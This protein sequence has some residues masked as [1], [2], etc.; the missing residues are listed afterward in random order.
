MAEGTA[1]A[2]LKACPGTASCPGRVATGPS[3]P[4]TLQKSSRT[5]P[6][7]VHAEGQPSYRQRPLPLPAPAP[8]AGRRKGRHPLGPPCPPVTWRPHLRPPRPTAPHTRTGSAGACLQ[9]CGARPWPHW[10]RALDQGRPRGPWTGC[11]AGRSHGL[12][13]GPLPVAQPHP[14]PPAAR[15]ARADDQAGG[16]HSPM[17]FRRSSSSGCGL[18]P[19]AVPSAGAAFPRESVPT[20]VGGA[21][22]ECVSP[23]ARGGEAGAG[24]GGV[25]V[26]ATVV[27]GARVGGGRSASPRGAGGTVAGRGVGTGSAEAAGTWGAEGEA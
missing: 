19:A 17:T 16:A 4:G 1:G 6:P 24:G 25:A 14:A 27:A 2:G 23:G 13:T 8:P 5:Q 9:T 15:S 21:A 11:E 26:G 18:G 12:G 7:T 20:V 3:D 10:L 22:D